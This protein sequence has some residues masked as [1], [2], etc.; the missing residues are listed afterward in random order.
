[1]ESDPC[2]NIFNVSPPIIVFGSHEHHK[3]LILALFDV[4]EMSF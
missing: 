3:N 4:H 2:F 1:M